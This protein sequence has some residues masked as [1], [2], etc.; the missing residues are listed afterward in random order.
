MSF[1]Q[2]ELNAALRDDF[3]L[4]LAKANA[5]LGNDLKSNWHHEAI[6]FQL[7]RIGDGALR[8]LV[9]T[10][11]PRHLKSITISVAWVAW[12]LGKY[13]EKRFVCVSY[14]SDLAM[15][16]ARDCRNIMLSEWYRKAFPVTVLK[17]EREHDF[18]TTR[19]GGRLSTTVGGTMTGRG[20]E[21]III[22]DPM[23]ADDGNSL[24]A[25]T[26]VR[27][28]FSNTLMSRLDDR[29]T[30]VIILVMQRLH[31]DDLAGH[32]LESGGW[33]HLSLPAI[34]AD[35]ETIEIAHGEFHT[36]QPGDV[37]HPEMTSREELANMAATMGSAAFSAQ[38]LQAPV[39]VQGN[40]VRREW[41]K[42]W[43]RMP[44][45]QA[46]DLIVQSWD[47][48][49]KDGVFSDYS[50]GITALLRKKD[51][52]ILDIFRGRL[53]F[54]DLKR[55]VVSEALSH[56]AD[57]VLI[58]DAASGQQLL[59]ILIH[60]DHN[61][62]PRPVR[63]R[64]EGDKLTRMSAQSALIEQGRLVLPLNAS[65]LADFEHELFAFPN[66]RHDDQVD[67]LAQLLE[68]VQ[69]RHEGIMFAGF[70]GKLFDEHGEV[71]PENNPDDW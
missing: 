21:I 11:P 1:S 60:E 68:W 15:K 38:Y 19:G 25:R 59:Q 42:R 10:M 32:L 61:G 12:M 13:P 62:M 44:E 31:E 63:R 50:V 29:S 40:I 39:P 71:F 49:N 18:E 55:R 4:F 17:S 66:G 8:R 3:P 33:E 69:T 6:S 23:K 9:V 53:Q 45:R 65:W 5:E 48:A 67:A 56:G 24:L 70:G 16:H 37:L 46:G 28:W 64:P 27:D 47:T 22:D 35:L 34:A 43:D 36:R 54:P 58:E 20:G 30:G 7:D 2:A 52:Y 41:L 26:K 51:V 57:T 14:A